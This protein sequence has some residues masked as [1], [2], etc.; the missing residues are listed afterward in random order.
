MTDDLWG[1]LPNAENL[2]TPHAILLEQGNLLT[3]K[4]RGLLN[5]V[6]GRRQENQNFVLTFQIIAPPLNNYSYAICSV[7]HPITLYPALF[8]THGRG[9]QWERCN[10]E[11]AFVDRLRKELGSDQVQ[12][13]ITGLLA[14]IRADMASKS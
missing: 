1:D 5:G 2:R 7:Q 3:E 10:D 8:L 12:R 9:A 14:Q 11:A 4:T 13:V 6:V